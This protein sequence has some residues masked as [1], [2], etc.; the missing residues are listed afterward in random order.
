MVTPSVGDMKEHIE[1]MQ[2]EF[3]DLTLKTNALNSFIHGSKVFKTLDA[4]EQVRMI[5]QAGFMEA[6]AEIL[7]ARI[8]VAV[9]R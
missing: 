9:K 5:K 8:W 1:R 2:Q 6:Y 7:D 3:K 4:Y